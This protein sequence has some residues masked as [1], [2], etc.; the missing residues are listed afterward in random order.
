MIFRKFTLLCLLSSICSGQSQ[1]KNHLILEYDPITW[2]ENLAIRPNGKILPITTTSPLLNELDPATGTLQLVHDFSS[3]GNA[4]QGIAE[5][6]PDV[7]AVNV[8]T[9]T[10]AANLSCTPGSVSSWVVDYKRSRWP[11][12]K[13]NIRMV[14][15]FPDAGFLNGI[16]ALDSNTVLIADSFLGGIWSLNIHTGK[17]LQELVPRPKHSTVRSLSGLLSI[18]ETR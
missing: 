15:G 7:F 3:Y 13:P 10:I 2:V 11:H 16:A 8:L 1:A 18:S 9:C 17:I 12:A 4:I 5:V 14:A 6:A